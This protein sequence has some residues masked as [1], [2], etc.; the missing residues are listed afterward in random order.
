M[1]PEYWATQSPVTDPGEAAA[2]VIDDL[3]S[4]LEALRYAASQLV[5]H[6][7]G[8][9]ESAGVAKE[10]TAEIST[11]YAEAML[12]RILSF[13]AEGTTSL[14][15]PRLGAERTIGC[16]RDSVVLFVA[17]ARHKG[18]PARPR[19]GYASNPTTPWWRDH[20]VAEV[21]DAKEKRW[22]LVEVEFED[23]THPDGTPN[24]EGAPRREGKDYLDLRPGID[25]L[26][27]PDAWTRARKGEADP[28]RFVV[29]PELDI[30]VLRGWPH[31]AHNVVHDLASLDKK[32][33]LLW[34]TWGIQSN[35][36]ARV[37]DEDAALLDEICPVLLDLAITP[38]KVAE[39]AAKKEFEIPKVV[40]SPDPDGGPMLDVDVSKVLGLA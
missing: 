30:P 23:E 3:D 17:L 15:R 4:S 35:W 24:P 16:C 20:V 33:M 6:Y 1:A 12:S 5:F 34:D 14:S 25:F 22:R 29:A 40:T 8:D 2:A 19:V 9:L 28:D 31:L 26:V 10:R 13:D 7:R 27:G 32:E 21:W 11:R 39:L 36:R 18:I 38:E 37:P